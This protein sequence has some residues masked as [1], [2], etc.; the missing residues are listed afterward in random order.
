MKIELKHILLGDKS[1][2][3]ELSIDGVR[4]CD[5]LE[6]KVRPEGVKIYGQTAIPYGTYKVRLTYSPHFKMITP[7]IQDVPQFQYIRIHPGNSSG[8]TEGCILVG[9]W[10]GKKADWI[11]NSRDAF[12]KLMKVLTEADNRKEEITIK[13]ESYG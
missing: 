2:I 6:D 1:T 7:E 3:G 13:I 12:G 11:S 10:D 9:T 4:I 5:T 8:D